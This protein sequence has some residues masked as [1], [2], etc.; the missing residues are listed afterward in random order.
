MLVNQRRELKIC[1]FEKARDLAENSMSNGVGTTAWMA[2]EVISGKHYN[3]KC[4]V[5]SWAIIFWEVLARKKPYENFHCR[6]AILF[7]VPKGL[8]PQLL[9]NFSD[10]IKTLLTKSWTNDPSERPSI[11]EIEITMNDILSRCDA[12]NSEPI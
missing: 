4:D 1:D 10:Q 5:Y 8:R 12:Q 3:E 9:Q 7:A 2:P 6:E 11:G